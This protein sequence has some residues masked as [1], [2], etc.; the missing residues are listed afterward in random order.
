MYSRLY[1]ADFSPNMATVKDDA[2]GVT[3]YTRTR[4]AAACA[5]L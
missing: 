3:A 4:W 5:Q 1:T 2:E